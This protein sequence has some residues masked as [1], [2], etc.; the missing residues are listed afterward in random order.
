MTTD[1]TNLKRLDDDKWRIR[2]KYTTRLTS[3][4][5]VLERV[6]YGTLREAQHERDRLKVAA[7]NGNL[8]R[9]R[10][11]GDRVRDY[12]DS[13]Y[14]HRKS[15]EGRRGRKLRRSTIERDEYAIEHHIQ[16]EIGD[17]ILDRIRLVDLEHVV[18]AWVEKEKPNGEPYSNGSI[19]TWIKVV[20]L[21]LRHAYRM[22]G[23]G[24][25]PAENLRPLPKALSR[26]QALTAPQVGEFLA[27]AEEMFPQ[28]HAM[29]FLGFATGARFSELSALHWDDVDDDEG[30]IHFAHSQYRGTRRKLTKSDR[31]IQRPLTPKIATALRKHRR[32]LADMKHPGVGNGI[33]FPARVEDPAEAA[34]NGY[35]SGYTLRSAMRRVS[36]K[37]S[38]QPHLTPHDMRRTFNSLMLESGISPQLLQAM[39]GHVTDEMTVHYAHI[40]RDAKADAVESLLE[41]IGSADRDPVAGDADASSGDVGVRK[42]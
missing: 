1:T 36:G 27:R 24:A 35:M 26:G 42:G 39:T 28:H 11:T 5:K 16:P 41:Q 31:Y 29:L 12:I 20:R 18:D 6:F 14:R 4:Q 2:F 15:R 17:W 38:Y 23:L 25:S 19:N 9:P 21:L 32:R 8:N 37:L 13:Y 40:S 30:V 7:R 34:G 22:A 33:I 10:A 3:E